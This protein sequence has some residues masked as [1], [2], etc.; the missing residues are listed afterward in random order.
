M[1]LGQGAA[2]LGLASRLLSDP[3][4][5]RLGPITFDEMLKVLGLRLIVAID[6]AIPITAARRERPAMARI[7]PCNDNQPPGYIVIRASTQEYLREMARRGG[8][9]SGAARRAKEG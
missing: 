4:T 8:I 5:K 9:A 7:A 6:P 3:P 2:T 1:V